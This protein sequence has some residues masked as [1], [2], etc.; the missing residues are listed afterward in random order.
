MNRTHH[1]AFSLVEL[2]VCITILAVLLSFLL[3]SLTNARAA[4]RTTI[5]ASQMRQQAIMTGQYIA[6]S[7]GFLPL[8]TTGHR[9][10]RTLSTG[11]GGIQAYP[12]SGLYSLTRP[13]A[14]VGTCPDGN[15]G[16]TPKGYGWFYAQNYLPPAVS[17]VT[18]V[19]VRRPLGIL[20]CPSTQQVVYR[21][22]IQNG[23]SWVEYLEFNYRQYSNLT[24][25]LSNHITDN[26]YNPQ[27]VSASYCCY[28]DDPLV[29][30][31]EYMNR[32]WFLTSGIK[33]T[34]RVDYWKPGNAWAV[35][36]EGWMVGGLSNTYPLTEGWLKKHGN[37]VNVM[38]IDGHVTFTGKDISLT[39]AG[40]TLSVPPAVYYSVTGGQSLA[41]AYSGSN[42]GWA[43]AAGGG[44][45]RILPLW[46]HYETGIP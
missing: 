41:N 37:G 32:G 24:Y 22:S 5:C 33:Y 27:G 20:Q 34:G 30:Y 44:D 23:M 15:P 29:T 6:D 10:T 19:R 36:N 38:Y 35:D 17:K 18:S 13:Q 11:S 8:P 1:A 25:Y 42:A 9:L 40:V 16:T 14:A 46:T 12:S 39:T 7:R 26:G 3:P 31:G 43:F 4:A 28:Q 21:G 45:G 2:L